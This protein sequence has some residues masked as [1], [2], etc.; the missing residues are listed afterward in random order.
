MEQKIHMSPYRSSTTRF[1]NWSHARNEINKA[2][3]NTKF[4]EEVGINF[5]V[6]SLSPSLSLSLYLLF[7]FN[8]HFLETERKDPKE[9]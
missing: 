7:L 1:D 5:E 8:F 2:R 9:A 3:K 6:S 4:S